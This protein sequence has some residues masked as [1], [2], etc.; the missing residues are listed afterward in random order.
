MESLIV[1][2]AR[3]Q[4]L[5]QQLQ[6]LVD[7]V[8][9]GEAHATVNKTMAK[10]KVVGWL[11][12]NTLPANAPIYL[13]EALRVSLLKDLCEKNDQNEAASPGWA[14]KA[15]FAFLALAGTVVAICQGFDGIATL[16]GLTSAIPA[17]FIFFAGIAFALLS[18]GVF[19]GFDLV[20]ISRNLGVKLSKTRQ[21]LDIFVEQSE[22]IGKLRKVIDD[23]Y[24]DCINIKQLRSLQDMTAMLLLR[25]NALDKARRDYKAALDSP[26]LKM[27]KLIFS[28]MSGVLFFSAGF[29]AAQTLTTALVGLFSTA[30]ASAFLPIFIPSV[31]IGIAALGIYWFVERPGFENLVGRWLGLE[32]SA[33]D[34]LTD[35]DSVKEQRGDLELLQRKL[36]KQIEKQQ[37][38]V[39][40]GV[41]V[42]ELSSALSSN[43]LQ[44][45]L[46]VGIGSRAA[47]AGQSHSAQDSHPRFFYRSRSL[48][49]IDTETTRMDLQVA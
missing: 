1:F 3:S 4:S 9:L 23:S 28:A 34:A 31:C 42:A 33:I 10:A 17:A 38:L 20:E 36:N 26:Y 30:A 22:L 7:D 5:I 27:A 14:A 46:S 24:I 19:Y 11:A 35:E 48:D 12:T 39:R 43:E 32:Q 37:R 2:S 8:F 21:L 41:E 15:L 13:V 18:V 25:F 44:S 47:I 49:N 6:P 29:F 45:G 16:L 40:Y